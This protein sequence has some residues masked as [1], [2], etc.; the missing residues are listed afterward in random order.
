M[1]GH[2]SFQDLSNSILQSHREILTTC[3]W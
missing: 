3:M 1:G 2:W